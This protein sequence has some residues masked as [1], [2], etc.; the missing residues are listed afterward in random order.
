VTCTPPSTGTCA[1]TWLRAYRDIRAARNSWERAKQIADRL[2]TENSGHSAMHIAVRA[3]LC[4]T[5]WRGG[6]AAN[7]GFDELREMATAADDKVSLAYGMA[8]QVLALN[9][10]ARH[11]ESSE[12][13][14]ELAVLLESI[15][16]PTLTVTLLWAAANMKPYRGEITECLRLTDRIIELAN[17]DVQKGNVIIE[18]PLTM[19]I[20]LR[21]VAHACVN[22]PG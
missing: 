6:S 21:A 18:S 20:V 7:T 4:A 8:G 11:R 22:S 10:T 3:R 19:A 17:G 5:A 9:L 1:G 2:P 12:L 13:A 16:V 15:G 14:S